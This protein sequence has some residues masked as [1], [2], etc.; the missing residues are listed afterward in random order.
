MK[1]LVHVLRWAEFLNLAES[2][3]DLVAHNGN[4]V[5]A[6]NKILFVD[7]RFD[8]N[9]GI[10]FVSGGEVLCDVLLLFVDPVEFLASVGV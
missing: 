3:V 1:S 2:P 4:D 9:F 6:R 7:Q 10:D 5:V 8:P